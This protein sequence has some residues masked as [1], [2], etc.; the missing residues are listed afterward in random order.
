MSSHERYWP[1]STT[2]SLSCIAEDEDT[3][4]DRMLEFLTALKNRQWPIPAPNGLTFEKNHGGGG[5]GEGN[6]R[7]PWYIP[8]GLDV[9]D[10]GP[11]RD[12]DDD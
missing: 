2:Y 3:A 8:T 11:P 12:H 6:P 9:R 7:K 4:L 1:P 5:P 10:L